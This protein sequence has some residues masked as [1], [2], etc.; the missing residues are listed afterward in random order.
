MSAELL[1]LLFETTL[2]ASA[3]VALVLALRLPVRRGFGARAAYA[4]WLLVPAALIAVL[5]PA[6]RLEATV[7]PTAA[8]PLAAGVVQTQIA[9]PAAPVDPA[10]WILLA[11]A[12]GAAALAGTLAVRQHRFLRT[13]GRLHVRADGNWSAESFAGPAVIG[14]LRGRVVLPADFDER[15]TPTQR[16]LV[17]QHER[18]HL[19]RF[20]LAA[21]L[22]DIALRCLHWF[23]PLLH[24]A[25]GRFRFDQ[26]LA[27]DALVLA[28]HP[29][30]RRDYADAMLSTQ[31][32]ADFPPLGCHW[33]PAHPLKERI[34]MLKQ[35][36]PGTLRNAFGAVLAVALSLSAGYAAWAAQPARTSAMNSPLD[37]LGENELGL[38]IV[39]RSEDQVLALY[40]GVPR[41]GETHSVLEPGDLEDSGLDIGFDFTV[42][43]L[44]GDAADLIFTVRR[45]GEVVSQPR[46]LLHRSVTQPAASVTMDPLDSGLPGSLHFELYYGTKRE[47]YDNIPAELQYPRPDTVAATY[48]QLTPLPYPSDALADEAEGTVV[49]RVLVAVDGTPKRI[50]LDRSSGDRRL[51]GW[52]QARVRSWRFNPAQR[53]GRAVEDWVFVP[54]TFS[55]DG[56]HDAPVLQAGALEE[57]YVNAPKG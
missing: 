28:Q 26:E 34:K 13:L 53:D 50:E 4:L 57:I 11:W 16:V 3:G 45:S 54:V 10:P 21:N 23:N 42:A 55:L 37:A 35:P 25:A 48:R 44:A 40:E 20:D 43:A 1:Q 38:R 27:A 14:L 12:F 8:A 52:A 49:V 17:L 15:Y 22:L 6:P 46:I 33:Q 7:P 47:L 24:Y 18:A 51:D 39:L 41:Q 56:V 31:L 29:G 30:A 5:L 9:A 19:A 32:R 2:A 36:L